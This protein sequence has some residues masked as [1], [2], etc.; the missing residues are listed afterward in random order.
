VA[1]VQKTEEITKIEINIKKMNH[2]SFSLLCVNMC[3]NFNILYNTNALMSLACSEVY[4]MSNKK[5]SSCIYKYINTCCR[6]NIKSIRK[7][8]Y[9]FAMLK[10]VLSIVNGSIYHNV[11]KMF[12]TAAKQTNLS[13]KWSS[14]NKLLT[15]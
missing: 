12:N 1:P 9:H 5:D 4:R 8:I 6:Y 2:F 10:C 7:V 15:L 14:D 11:P 3:V 13:C